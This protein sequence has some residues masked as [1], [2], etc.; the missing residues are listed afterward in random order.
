MRKPSE[1]DPARRG[2]GHAPDQ[3]KQGGLA[4]T[5]RPL[6]DHELPLL[7][8]KAHVAHGGELVG[9]TH[10]K[11]LGYGAEFYHKLT[12]WNCRDRPLPTARK[13]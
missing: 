12:S 3:G 9:Q 4:R 6:D 1:H 2:P 5:A 10:G 11:A 7:D 13:G 8:D